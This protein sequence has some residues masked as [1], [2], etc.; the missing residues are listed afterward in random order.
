MPEWSYGLAHRAL[1]LGEASQMP[2]L[3]PK[4]FDEMKPRAWNVGGSHLYGW[5]EWDAGMATAHVGV[6][7]GADRH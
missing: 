7:R 4:A 1:G 2:G 3:M 6:R 5:E